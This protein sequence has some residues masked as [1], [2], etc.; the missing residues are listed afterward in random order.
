VAAVVVIV[1]QLE[2]LQPSI[3]VSRCRGLITGLAFRASR[4]D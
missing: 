3:V 4:T 1:R 2:R